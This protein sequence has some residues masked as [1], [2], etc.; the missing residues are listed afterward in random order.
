MAIPRLTQIREAV[1]RTLGRRAH[2]GGTLVYGAPFMAETSLELWLGKFIGFSWN[3][4]AE[5]K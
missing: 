4:V 1:Y 5:K 2:A 3:I